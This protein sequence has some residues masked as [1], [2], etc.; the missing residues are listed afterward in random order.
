MFRLGRAAALGATC[1]LAA[2]RAGGAQAS[3]S[4]DV[5]A[6]R[7]EYDGFLPSGAVSASPSLRLTNPSSSFI[8]RG[9]WLRFESGN[10]SV[11][12]LLAGS[13]FTPAFG[14]W[15]GEVAATAGASSYQGLTGF[16]HALARGRAHYLLSHG[17]VWVAGTLGRA[18]Y[19]DAARPIDAVAAGI[20]QGQRGLNFTV[21][22]SHTRVG[23]TSY[24]DVEGSGYWQ[25]GR[26]ELEGSLGARSGRGAGRGVYGEAVATAVLSQLLALTFGAGRYPTDPIR[27]SVSGRY[28]SIA[29]RVTGLSPRPAPRTV[30]EWPQAP[31]VPVTSIAGSNG[32]L[33]TTAIT[34]EASPAGT[35]LV[36]RAPGAAFVE[37]MGDFTDWQ[38]VMLTRVGDLWRLETRMA[39]GLR[40][41]NVRVDGGLWSVPLGATLEHDDFGAVVGTVVV[42]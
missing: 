9:T 21:A 30:P 19:D 29:L 40:R 2:L 28:A 25:K 37:V 42:P 7:V 26:I 31:V 35:T 17:G 36:I 23:D 12:G 38:P 14:R 22:I 39:S 15:R 41:L 8:L 10:S 5:G 16:A 3:V 24:A 20:W 4:L 32:H 33:A 13:V 11:Q 27:G 1:S 6:A 34:I 18:S